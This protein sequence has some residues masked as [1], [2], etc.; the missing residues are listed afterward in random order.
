M[1]GISIGISFTNDLSRYG[2]VFLL[3]HKSES[4]EMF[5]RCRNEIKKKTGK[6]IKILRCDQG[7]EYLSSEFLTYLGENRILSL[8]NRTLL[9]MARSMMSFATPPES[10]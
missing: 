8:W 6:S 4:I 10:F 7:G 5:N 1:P 2:Y 9:D 3:R